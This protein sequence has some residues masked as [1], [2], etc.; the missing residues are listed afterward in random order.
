MLIVLAILMEGCVEINPNISKESERIGRDPH[1]HTIYSFTINEHEYYK[2]YKGYVHS[3]DCKK[4]KQER[5]S[6]VNYIIK[7]L[8]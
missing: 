5:D 1:G 8:K 4:C 2:I 3:G 6:I 7:N